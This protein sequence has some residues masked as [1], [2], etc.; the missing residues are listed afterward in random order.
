MLT[1]HKM[2][3]LKTWKAGYDTHYPKH[4]EAGLTEKYLL[5]SADYLNEVVYLRTP[6]D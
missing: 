5:Q 1:S 3:D 4:V 6:S 2:R